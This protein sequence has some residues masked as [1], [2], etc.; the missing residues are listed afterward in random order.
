MI[1][2]APRSHRGGARS[3]AWGGDQPSGWYTDHVKTWLTADWHLGENR[4][5]LMGRPPYGSQ[6]EMVDVFVANHNSLVAPDDR[7]IVV[8]DAV[9]QHA[10]EFLEQVSRFNGVKTLI[11]G[12]H[13]RVFS[14][15]QFAPY[16][17][18]VI[19]EGNGVEII[20]GPVACYLTH[21]PTCGHP[22]RFNLVGHI[23]SAWKYQLNMFNVG[24]DVNHFYPVALDSIPDRLKAICEFYDQDVWVAYSE[25][26]Q[27]FEAIRGRKTSY[28]EY[29]QQS[30]VVG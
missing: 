28:F 4:F 10:P 27:P 7:V 17:E 6:Q 26:N 9:Y 20:A 19:P 18:T 13:D 15:E 11:R 24:V 21:Y 22:E 30:A 14:D 12:N 1:R 25:L 2:R 8:G 29:A 23:H 5:E 3:I 16:F